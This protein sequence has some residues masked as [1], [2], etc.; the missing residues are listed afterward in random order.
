MDYDHLMENT[1]EMVKVNLNIYYLPMDYNHLMENIQAM[2]KGRL[3][4]AC[5][6]REQY[7][8]EVGR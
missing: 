1:Q 2:V 8:L 6:S 5:A 3:S 4:I 7:L